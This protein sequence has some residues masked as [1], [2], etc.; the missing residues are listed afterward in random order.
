MSAAENSTWMK[1]RAPPALSGG[2]D[3]VMVQGNSLRGAM[4]CPDDPV[5][6]Q[7]KGAKCH[8]K[9]HATGI[10]QNFSLH[11]I[12]SREIQRSGKVPVDIQ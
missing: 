10:T 7:P 4:K 11:F 8:K 12:G 6:E 5:T 1:L 9:C 2:K 3:L